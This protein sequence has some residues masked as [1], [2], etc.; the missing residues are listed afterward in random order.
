MERTSIRSNRL[1]QWRVT[2]K[3]GPLWGR[4]SGWGDWYWCADGGT[5]PEAEAGSAYASTGS[6]VR[7]PLLAGMPAAGAAPVAGFYGQAHLTRHFGRM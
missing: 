1:W 7:G 3:T 4:G 6:R 2:G 5:D